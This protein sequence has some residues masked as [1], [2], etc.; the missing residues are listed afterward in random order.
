M[1]VSLPILRVRASGRPARR[2]C[3]RAV[4]CGVAACAV[5]ACLGPTAPAGAK[6]RNCARPGTVTLAS[7]SAARISRGAGMAR[8]RLYGCLRAVDRA[9]RLDHNGA[10]GTWTFGTVPRIAGSIPRGARRWTFAGRFAGIWARSSRRAEFWVYDLGTGRMAVRVAEFYIGVSGA[11]MRYGP[12]LATN[13]VPVWL[14][15]TGRDSPTS[16]VG[17]CFDTGVSAW[18][19]PCRWFDGYPGVYLPV[20]GLGRYDVI[21]NLRVSGTIARW[22]VRGATRSYNLTPLGA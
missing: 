5:L 20:I 21:T 12:L 11:G 17:A 8:S 9:Y 18:G 7:T 6:G 10:S 13:G 4:R 22:S 15:Y 16:Q 1:A 3:R 2:R 19:R 14:H